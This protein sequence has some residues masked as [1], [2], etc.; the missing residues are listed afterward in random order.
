MQICQQNHLN[1][2]GLQV[3]CQSKV[4]LQ[5]SR[6]HSSWATKSRRRWLA[7]LGAQV[8]KWL[9]LLLTALTRPPK[10]SLEKPKPQKW[11]SAGP[12]SCPTLPH[13]RKPSPTSRLHCFPKLS[14]RSRHYTA[15]GGLSSKWE[16]ESTN[17]RQGV[18]DMSTAHLRQHFW[19]HLSPALRIGPY[20]ICAGHL[21]A[22]L[23][24]WLNLNLPCP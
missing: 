16:W 3:W 1:L 10:I 21:T 8:P 6:T 9:L 23:F 2:P 5:F 22:S 24:Q 17:S 7:P 4:C 11:R 12:T 15:G 19:A 13:P 18:V 14:P 20:V